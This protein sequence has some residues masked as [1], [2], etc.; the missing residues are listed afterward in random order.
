MCHGSHGYITQ[1]M[2]KI[3]INKCLLNYVSQNNHFKNNDLANY[4]KNLSQHYNDQSNSTELIAPLERRRLSV[5]EKNVLRLNCNIIMGSE[6]IL[7]AVRARINNK[8]FHSFNYLRKGNTNSYTVCFKGLCA[9]Q[10]GEILH[11]F[12]YNSIVY[13]VIKAFEVVDNLNC[14]FS[15]VSNDFKQ[16]VNEK[17]FK[18][19]IN[20]IALYK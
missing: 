19:L 13:A 14:L 17:N 5:D 11:F 15:K 20:L 4:C 7:K 1:L 18:R 12:N 3:I 16:Y 10:F 6:E 9:Y 8:T 2:R